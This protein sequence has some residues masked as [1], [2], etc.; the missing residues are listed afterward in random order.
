MEDQNTYKSPDAEEPVI[1]VKDL[2]KSFEELDVLKGVN[3]SVYKGENVVVLGKSGSGKSVLIKIL[4]GLL[5]PDRGEV[6]VLGKEV[7]KLSNK[8][9]NDLRLRIGFS[10]QSS[11]L[12]DSMSIRQN[13]EFPLRMNIKNL[14]RKDINLAVEEVLSAVG[15]EDKID[16]MPAELSGGQRKRIGIA[17]TLILKPEIMLYDEPTAGLD[18]ITS[19]EINNLINEMQQKYNTSSI[20]ITHDLTCAKETGDRVGM[21][22]EGKFTRVGKFKDVFD[23]NDENVKGFY[24]YNFIE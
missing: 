11:A 15:L 13:L 24:N 21:F 7:D 8:E 12:Y 4:V 19:F 20:I 3:L 1:L 17:R 5:K 10:F 23:T 6:I 2:Y 22:V 16:Q 9:L 14:S 18:P